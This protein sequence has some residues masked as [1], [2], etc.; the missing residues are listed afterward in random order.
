MKK[1]LTLAILIFFSALTFSQSLSLINVGT[2]PDNNSGDP[3]RTAFI[4]T[5]AAITQVNRIGILNITA[6]GA[7]IS[8]LHGVTTTST[9][10][11]MLNTLRSDVQ[12]Q[13]DTKVSNATHTGDVT[14]SGALTLATVNSNPG[15]YTNTNLTVNAKGLVT[16]ASNGSGSAGSFNN[17]QMTGL[18]DLQS[19]RVGGSAASIISNITV[20]SAGL[21]FEVNG[22]PI[23]TYIPPENIVE[24]CVLP[25][26]GPPT[27]LKSFEELAARP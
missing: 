5:N 4:K 1:I 8:L 7:E 13:L 25:N 20:D 18:T 10:F 14:G 17:T 12:V 6:T 11:N 3:A 22:S 24:G 2:A 19:M 9:Q 16:A 27:G 15:T 21:I 26:I 23:Q